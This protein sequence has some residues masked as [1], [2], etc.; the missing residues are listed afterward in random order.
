MVSAT[1]AFGSSASPPSPPVTR[2]APAA[3]RARELGT[4][5][6]SR[7][8]KK[9]ASG[10]TETT[11]AAPIGVSLQP[12]I[13]SRTSR[14]R[15][16]AIAAEII[17]RAML[18]S[19]CGRPASRS[20]DSITPVAA[21]CRATARIGIPARSAIGTCSRKIDCQETSSVRRPPTA[22]P[23]AAPVAPAIA[24]IET[25]RR[26]D[27]TDAGSSSNTAVTAR[28]PPSACTQRAAISVLSSDEAPQA[29]QAPAKIA[30]P[31][32]AAR[33]GPTR[34]ATWAAGTAPSAITRLKETRTQ[35]TPATLVPISR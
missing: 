21:S 11:I 14:N 18:A 9:A 34:R 33:P 25:A 16:A 17:A 4:D 30:R 12:S 5:G 7:E 2:I 26:S 28:A 10:I 3:A 35:V 19:T 1:S 22:G 13:S 32:A 6:S 31:I 15:A 24:Q 8:P 23:S 29:R 20:S 27:P